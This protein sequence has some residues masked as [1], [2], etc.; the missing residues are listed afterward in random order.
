MTDFPAAVPGF[1]R[2]A[3]GSKW[4]VGLCGGDGTVQVSIGV[5]DNPRDIVVAA[6]TLQVTRRIGGGED[7][8]AAGVPSR[9]PYGLPI[10]PEEAIGA[11]FGATRRR[12]ATVPVGFN[13]LDDSGLGQLPLCA[14]W[15]MSVDSAVTVTSQRTGETMQATEFF[16]RHVPAC[17]SETIQLFVASQL[18]PT[19][20]WIYIPKDTLN[21]SGAI[22]S[23]EV[24][25][26][27][28]VRFD[29]VRVVP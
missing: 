25:L 23:A 14:S 15:R 24:V 1:A 29:A 2:R 28:P 20:G 26:T 22:D 10:T 12:V 7:F 6:D 13:Q 8:N 21:P 5:P 16:V 17:Y 19:T 3:H 18:Q 4:A 9:F 27:G 11:V